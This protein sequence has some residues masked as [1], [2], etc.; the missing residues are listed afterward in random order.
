MIF[1]IVEM[2][3]PTKHAITQILEATSKS[4]TRWHDELFWGFQ[5]MVLEVV[6]G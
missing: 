3:R 1:F 5:K 4:G 2:W 6:I